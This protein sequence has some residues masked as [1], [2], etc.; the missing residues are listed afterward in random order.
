M[1]YDSQTD[2]DLMAVLGTGQIE[3]LVPLVQRYQHKA[4]STAYRMLGRRDLAEDVMQEAFLRIHRAAPSYEP[5]AKFSTWFYRVVVNLCL[6]EQRRHKRQLEACRDF[7]EQVPSPAHEG[8]PV[9]AQ[10]AQEKQEAVRMALGKLRERERTVVVLQRYEGLSYREMAE[11]TGWSE[12]AIDS[13][14]V[15]AY[16]KLRQELKKFE[17]P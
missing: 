10:V 3:A 4:L 17:K 16:R 15:R 12:S 1:T 8:D 6:D 5:R 2:E 11:V 9:H 13:L 7:L 14:L